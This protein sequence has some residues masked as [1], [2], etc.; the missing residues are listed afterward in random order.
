MKQEI[1]DRWVARLRDP[2]S[3]QTKGALR[4]GDGRC[5]LGILCDIAVED[6]II[7]TKAADFVDDNEE[8]TWYYGEDISEEEYLLS[9]ATL[10]EAVREWAGFITANGEW[11]FTP[12]KDVTMGP[13]LYE[14]GETHQLSLIELND[15]YNYSFPAIADAIEEHWEEL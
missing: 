15:D 13:H 12:E 11:T 8:T 1:K 7:H 3:L 14:A 10:P 6:G 9:D 2:D 5:C 4:R